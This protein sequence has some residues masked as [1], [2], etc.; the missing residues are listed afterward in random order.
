MKSWI[1]FLLGLFLLLVPTAILSY[2]LSPFPGSQGLDSLTAVYYVGLT[3]PLVQPL[4]LLMRC[5]ETR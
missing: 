4:G 5:P 1:I 3:V 2:L